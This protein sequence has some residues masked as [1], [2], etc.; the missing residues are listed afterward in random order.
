[1]TNSP[2]EHPAPSVAADDNHGSQTPDDQ[3]HGDDLVEAADPEALDPAHG[4]V[5]DG[6]PL[7]ES[8]PIA[9][10]TDAP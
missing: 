3:T 9:K 7:S 5:P 2:V 8:D 6:S 4:P 1:M 10:A